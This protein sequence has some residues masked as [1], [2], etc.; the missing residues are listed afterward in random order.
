MDP[1]HSSRLTVRQRFYL[2]EVLVGS[3]SPACASSNMWQHTQRMLG[4][5]GVRAR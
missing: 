2:V 4:V 1:R 5:K 3:G